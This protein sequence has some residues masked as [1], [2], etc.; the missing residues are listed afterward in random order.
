[1]EDAFPIQIDIVYLKNSPDQISIQI[2]K[3]AVVDTF[4]RSQVTI[5]AV[6]APNQTAYLASTYLAATGAEAN[7]DFYYGSGWIPDYGDPAT[8]LETMVPGGAGYMTKVIG[9]W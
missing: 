1:M 4:G 3:A 6:E 9:L 5:N 7:Y 8:F 2:L